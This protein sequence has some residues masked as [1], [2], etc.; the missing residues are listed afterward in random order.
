MAESLD[1]LVSLLYATPCTTQTGRTRVQRSS[2]QLYHESCPRVKP[3]VKQSE[4]T[5]FTNASK[6]PEEH[7][8]YIKK[9]T[10]KRHGT[11]EKMNI[12]FTQAAAAGVASAAVLLAV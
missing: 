1:T 10:G 8:V 9:R 12:T 3:R 4:H 2:K 6:L 5:M 11:A 7:R